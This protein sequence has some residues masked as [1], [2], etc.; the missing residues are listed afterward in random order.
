[1]KEIRLVIAV[2][3][4]QVWEAEFGMDL[5]FFTNYLASHG[6]I[7]GMPISFRL[8]NKRGSILANMREDLVKEAIDNGSTHVLFLDSDQTFPA[9]VFHQLIAHKKKIVAAN[10]AT[11]MLPPQPTARL[12]D[13]VELYTEQDSTGLVEV[14]R[15]G[16]GIMLIDLNVF[17]REGMEQP[18]FDQHWNPKLGAY[19][20]E[21]WSFCEKL[22]NAGVKLYVDQDLSKQVGHVGKLNYGHD[23]I[24]AAKMR[25]VV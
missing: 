25:E 17:K 1:M 4:T 21:D 7:D 15:I 9:D 16:T 3:S 13:G 18:W 11:K 8:H 2:P 10:V 5:V 22:E 24:V 19:T 14:W 20:G 6:E 12:A 23:M